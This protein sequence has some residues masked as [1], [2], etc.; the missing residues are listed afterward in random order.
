MA[1]KKFR[2]SIIFLAL[3][4]MVSSLAFSQEF[5]PRGPEGNVEDWNIIKSSY[6]TIFVDKDVDLRSV[7]R[8]IDVGFAR[9]DPFERELYYD[10]GISD[11]ERLA[12]KIDTIVRK[13]KK[14]LDMHP[15]GFHVNIRIYEGDQ[16]MWNIY[17]KIFKER[18]GY[19]AFYIH[20]FRT[21]Y[22]SLSNVSED[23]LAHEIGHAIIDNYFG[24]LPPHKIRE[25]LAAYCD[26]HLKD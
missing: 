11:A 24:I 5:G 26:V 1:T 19:K 3:F 23:V 25:L 15:H 17:E 14:T 21:V 13:D 18:K 6:A 16:D 10:K 2:L 9:Y 20:K 22:I 12:N 8:R 4:I 7:S